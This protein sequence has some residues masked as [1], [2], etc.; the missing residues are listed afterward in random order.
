MQNN[1]D[2]INQ[3]QIVANNFKVGNFI[4]AISKSKKILH[5]VP[6]NEF[7]LNIVGLS[8]LNLGR[9]DDAKNLYLKIA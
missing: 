1:K 8:Y 7:L 6:N 9:L 3:I 4:D 2:L 5:Q